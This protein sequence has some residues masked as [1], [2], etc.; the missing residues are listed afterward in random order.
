MK[1]KLKQENT[2]FNNNLN[3]QCTVNNV[4]LKFNTEG[5]LIIVNCKLL[6][7]NLKDKF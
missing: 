5:V 3:V 4:Q 1:L 7:V 6:I 2:H